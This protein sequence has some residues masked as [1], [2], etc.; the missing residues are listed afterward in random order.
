MEG[1]ELKARPVL[2]RLVLMLRSRIGPAIYSE[3]RESIEEVMG[4]ALIA[5]K[6]RLAVAESLTGG[7]VGERIVR[8]PGASR[9]YAGDIVATKRREG[10]S[11]ASLRIDS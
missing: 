5:R 11:L 10:E 9:Y 4:A 7:A 3:G 6:W 2:D 8:V 1:E